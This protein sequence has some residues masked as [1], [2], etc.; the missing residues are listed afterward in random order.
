MV[1]KATK[2]KYF[3]CLLSLTFLQLNAFVFFTARCKWFYFF[4][5]FSFL[6]IFKCLL[7]VE[8]GTEIHQPSSEGNIFE[9]KCKIFVEKNKS[10][11]I[12]KQLFAILT[13]HTR[14]CIQVFFFV[15]TMFLFIF[16]KTYL[17]CINFLYNL[18]TISV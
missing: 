12:R 9:I 8:Y 11:K 5:C 1:A 2:R 15:N 6:Y 17:F 7:M 13:Y 18:C 14:R 4:L 16:L 10:P 3:V